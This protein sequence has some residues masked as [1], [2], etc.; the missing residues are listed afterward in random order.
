MNQENKDINMLCYV[1]CFLKKNIILLLFN[2]L[3]LFILFIIKNKRKEI[4]D[5]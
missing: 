5:S 2:Y 1:I 3:Y 4:K